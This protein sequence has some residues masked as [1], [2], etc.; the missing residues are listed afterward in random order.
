MTKVQTEFDL[1]ARYFAPLASNPGALGLIDDVGVMR[2]P[3]GHDLVLS[4]DT[5]IAG[6]HFL[7]REDAGI[8]AKK[9]L[10]SALSDIIAKGAEPSG[11][12]LA[13]SLPPNWTE[14][15]IEAFCH[16]LAQDQKHYGLAL[17]GGDT[18]KT[19]GPLTITVSVIGLTSQNAAVLR[20]TARPGD[21]IVVSGTIG[22][23][24]LGLKLK[25]DETLA[26][27]LGLSAASQAAL[28][29]RYLVP[30]PRL[31][32][33][34]GLRR[35]ASAAMDISDGL[36]GDVAKLCTASGVCATV[37]VED[38]PLSPAASACVEADPT[39]MHTILGG[40]DDYEILATVRPENIAGLSA[41]ATAARIPLSVIGTITQT[42]ETGEA[43]EAGEA[44]E[45]VDANGL[46]ALRHMSYTHFD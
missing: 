24:A 8:V 39:L 28:M 20:S 12:L 11:Y 37:R 33:F 44:P 13:L 5:V 22:D 27:R 1:I 35:W 42:G 16:A 36:A 23:A 29:D 21:S 14:M 32:L 45:F 2:S 4:T 40:G 38:V 10:R 6:V 31:G 18:T 25:Q 26:R 19:P 30:Q 17:M 3:A 15:W 34:W 7:A 9:A 46:M 41:E 43:G